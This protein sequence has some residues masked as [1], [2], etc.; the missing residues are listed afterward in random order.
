MLK[1][2]L[3][4]RHKRCGGAGNFLNNLADVYEESGGASIVNAR[5]PLQHIG[6]FNSVA[7]GLPFK[8][9][10]LRMDGIYFDRLETM[11][12]ND[13]LNRR[14]FRSIRYANGIVFQSEFSKELIESHFGPIKCP[15]TIISNGSP[16][17]RTSK[18]RPNRTKGTDEK[19]IIICSAVWRRHK[20]LKETIEV[21]RALNNRIPCELIVLGGVEENVPRYDFVQF[22]GNVSHGVLFNFLKKAH[23]F[24]H[25][26]W[27]DNCPNSVVEALSHRI[28][29]VCSNQGGTRELVEKTRGGIVAECDEAIDCSSLVDLYHPPEPNIGKIVEAIENVAN[30]H[31]QFVK[32]M[33]VN[34]V[35]I[36]SV[37]E[38]YLEF[39]YKIS[40]RDHS[41]YSRVG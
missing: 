22:K 14:I 37:S 16:I 8:P 3:Q 17:Y 27:L 23:V 13:A 6:L 15:S 2:A 24:L 20:R 30:N 35:D 12:S 25:L 26:C 18:N 41:I 28:P 19:L 5:N 29:V 38:K 11:G 39:L 4:P 31:S 1:I 36:K 40:G 10:V 33:N 34:P 9:Y 32:N 21:V 7:N